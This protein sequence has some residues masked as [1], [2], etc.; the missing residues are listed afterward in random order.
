[1]L[2]AYDLTLNFPRLPH[3]VQVIGCWDVLLCACVG[4]GALGCFVVRR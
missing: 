2:A 3:P 4:V 1:M